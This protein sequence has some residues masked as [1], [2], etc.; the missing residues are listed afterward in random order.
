MKARRLNLEPSVLCCDH[1]GIPPGKEP[2][3]QAC[4]IK[5]VVAWRADYH[6][7]MLRSSLRKERA[8][9]Y[10][11][12]T[13]PSAGPAQGTKEPPLLHITSSLPSLVPG[14]R[15]AVRLLFGLLAVMAATAL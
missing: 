1:S 3:Y 15:E 10:D 7:V 5:V 6:L 11:S 12:T 8:L 2:E 4:F 9:M 13:G 14:R